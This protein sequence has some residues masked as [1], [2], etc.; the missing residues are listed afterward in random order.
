MT[1][2]Y[3]YQK[4]NISLEPSPDPH[5]IRRATIE[6]AANRWAAMGWRTVAVMEVSGSDRR[7]GYAD[8]ILVERVKR[9]EDNDGE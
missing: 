4:I 8:S 1:E 2:I 5:G 9:T 3:E 7:A 6:S